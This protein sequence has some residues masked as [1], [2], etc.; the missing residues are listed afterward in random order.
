MPLTYHMYLYYASLNNAVREKKGQKNFGRAGGGRQHELNTTL[1]GRCYPR[2]SGSADEPNTV[3]PRTRPQGREWRRAGGRPAC[4]RLRAPGP[5]RT[6]L[7][8]TRC[9][10]ALTVGFDGYLSVGDGQF[11]RAGGHRRV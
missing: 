7:P 5:P 9:T 11:L 2:F 3:L 10:R 6:P 4:K 8:L 1:E